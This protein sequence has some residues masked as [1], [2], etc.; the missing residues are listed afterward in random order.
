MG[1]RYETEFNDMD[2]KQVIKDI[3][4]KGPSNVL[5]ITAT[6]WPNI[7]Y[8]DRNTKQQT[9]RHHL[10]KLEEKGEVARDGKGVH[11][12]INTWWLT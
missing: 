8:Y 3:L 6:I 4:A 7:P 5:D 11:G 9:V 1:Y 10:Y 2:L 12:K